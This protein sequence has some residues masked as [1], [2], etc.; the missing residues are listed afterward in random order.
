M[1]RRVFL[2]Y[3]LCLADIGPHARAQ[4]AADLARADEVI[5]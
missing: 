2:V 3:V 4:G 1:R 5:E